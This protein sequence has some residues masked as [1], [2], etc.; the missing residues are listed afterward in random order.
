ML[1]VDPVGEAVV[2][3]EPPAGGQSLSVCDGPALADSGA[4]WV[5]TVVVVVAVLVT[6]GG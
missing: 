2:V 5:A 1:D 6:V 4:D 3:G